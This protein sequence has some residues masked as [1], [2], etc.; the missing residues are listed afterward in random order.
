M[1]T[2][3]QQ[4][5]LVHGIAALLEGYRTEDEQIARV[6]HALIML[7]DVHRDLVGDANTLEQLKRQ[8]F[9]IEKGKKTRFRLEKTEVR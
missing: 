2:T 7:T 1:N 6:K 9:S 3:E 5:S 8:I 4:T